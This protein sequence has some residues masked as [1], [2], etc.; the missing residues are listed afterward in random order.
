MEERQWLFLF[1][2][3]QWRFSPGSKWFFYF[4]SGWLILPDSNTVVAFMA[5]KSDKMYSTI[6]S[7]SEGYFIKNGNK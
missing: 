6:L 5:T 2:F 1:D 3:W 7:E 4:D